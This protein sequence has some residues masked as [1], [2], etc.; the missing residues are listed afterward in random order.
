MI[1]KPTNLL[2]NNTVLGHFLA[3]H[4]AHYVQKSHMNRTSEDKDEEACHGFSVIE[5]VVIGV[6]K[7]K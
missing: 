4:L 1:D 6:M 2:L 3:N 5:L 7:G